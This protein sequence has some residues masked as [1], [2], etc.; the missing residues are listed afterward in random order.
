MRAPRHYGAWRISL[1]AVTRSY[2]CSS[3]FPLYPRSPRHSRR[4][5]GRDGASAPPAGAGEAPGKLVTWNRDRDQNFIDDLLD[6]RAPSEK[7]D[8]IV[9]FNRC[10]T[11]CAEGTE[12]EALKFLRRLGKVDHI[13]SIVT[14]AVVLQV[15]VSEL[16]SIAERPEVAMVEWL[17][18]SQGMLDVS[19]PAVRVSASGTFSPNTGRELSD[20]SVHDH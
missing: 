2:R 16:R 14:F 5:N 1:C 12:H 8:I 20:R 3:S 9:D 15:P 19:T 7:V 17:V 18:P 6:G 4:S 10:V 13:S 11:C